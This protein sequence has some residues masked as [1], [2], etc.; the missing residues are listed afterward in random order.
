M[1]KRKRKKLNSLLH[2]YKHDG[3]I[4][5]S[6]DNGRDKVACDNS[7]NTVIHTREYI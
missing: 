2:R 3:N 7:N 6:Y 1:T 4:N 5:N